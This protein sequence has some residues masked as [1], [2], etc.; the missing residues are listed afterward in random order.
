LTCLVVG[1]LKGVKPSH[2]IEIPIVPR[3]GLEIAYAKITGRRTLSGD[4]YQSLGNVDASDA[5]AAIR[6]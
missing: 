6:S 3:Q 1:E 2:H 5:G 4:G